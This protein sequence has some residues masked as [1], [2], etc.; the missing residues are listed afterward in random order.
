VASPVAMRQAFSG[1]QLTADYS[2][3]LQAL[4]Q[5]DPAPSLYAV[6]VIFDGQAVAPETQFLLISSDGKFLYS[7]KVTGNPRVAAERDKPQAITADATFTPYST[8]PWRTDPNWLGY[9]DQGAAL[10]D[11]DHLAPSSSITKIT[12]IGRT[13]VDYN[14][15]ILYDTTAGS[16]RYIVRNGDLNLVR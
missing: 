14:W 10:L 7:Y 5:R 8:V 15:M 1:D 9:V 4:A 12:M 6:A 13:G 2:L 16:F 3:V 11:R